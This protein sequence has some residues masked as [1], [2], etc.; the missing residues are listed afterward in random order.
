M[1]HA[2]LTTLNGKQIAPALHSQSILSLHGFDA[3]NHPSLED[4]D[5]QLA[6]P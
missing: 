3:Y 2:L 4:D 1:K 6:S 5:E